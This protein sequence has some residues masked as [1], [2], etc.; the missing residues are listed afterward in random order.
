MATRGLTGVVRPLLGELPSVARIARTASSARAPQT[1]HLHTTPKAQNAHPKPPYDPKLA[2]KAFRNT[3]T[4]R[5]LTDTALLQLAETKFA[6]KA[7]TVALPRAAQDNLVGTLARAAVKPVVS[8]FVATGKDLEDVI[9]KVWA[10]GIKSAV[11]DYPREMDAMPSSGTWAEPSASARKAEAM[12]MALAQHPD[13]KLFAVKPT[14]YLPEE[15]I[16]NPQKYPQA[17][18]WLQTTLKVLAQTAADHRKVM[19]IDAE[20]AKVEKTMWPI[21]TQLAY[22]YPSVMPTIQHT[23]RDAVARTRAYFEN[24]PDS[25]TH[26]LGFKAVL[27]SYTGDRKENPEAY[28]QNKADT[29]AAF[30]ATRDYVVPLASTGKA[31]YLPCTHNEDLILELAPHAKLLPF[32][33]GNLLGFN[34]GPPALSANLGESVY[35]PFACGSESGIA[36]EY[37]ERRLY[38]LRSGTE[39]SLSPRGRWVR[40]VALE[41]RLRRTFAKAQWS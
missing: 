20:T 2:E 1:A 4:S 25:C 33:I 11:Y 6:V 34:G 21:V 32:G 10:L 31:L 16:A 5:L 36:N 18:L 19:I 26:P 29:L 17:I 3:S 12:N 41:E 14:A 37:V 22:H 23:R 13:V 30:R 24:R 9:A 7:A 35:V 27:G 39:Q 38:E 28:F 40:T 15:V 8:L